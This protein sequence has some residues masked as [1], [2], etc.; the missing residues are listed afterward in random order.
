[1]GR[2]EPEV[3]FPHSLQLLPDPLLM[4]LRVDSIA[5]EIP[6]CETNIMWVIVKVTNHKPRRPSRANFLMAL[7]FQLFSS[8]N[9]SED[10]NH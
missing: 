9:K 7:E 2:E 6:L 4:W 3:S 1:M 8:T 10:Q 5:G